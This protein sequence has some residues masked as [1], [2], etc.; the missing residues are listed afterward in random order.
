MNNILIGGAKVM[1][2]INKAKGIYSE[3][4]PYISEVK[5]VFRDEM[6]NLQS[7]AQQ[8]EKIGESIAEIAG[9]VDA[10]QDPMLIQQCQTQIE[11]FAQNLLK[12]EQRNKELEDALEQIAIQNEELKSANGECAQ[13]LKQIEELKQAY[14]EDMEK[15]EKALAEMARQ[16]S[17]SFKS[18]NRGQT[19]LRQEVSKAPIRANNDEFKNITSDVQ[20]VSVNAPSGQAI[21]TLNRELKDAQTKIQN[22]LK[23]HEKE[24]A[25]V[26]EKVVRRSRALEELKDFANRASI[27]LQNLTEKR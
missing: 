1:D 18:R 2:L 17:E 12:S 3:T 25:E 24:M 10:P 16:Q 8:Q 22:I 15:A 21:E 11:E 13:Y 6:R 9:S 14:T 26:E 23:R 20:D 19:D 27:A 4:K 7:Q 5:S